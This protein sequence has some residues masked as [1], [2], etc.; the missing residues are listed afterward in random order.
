MLTLI[1]HGDVYAPEHLGTQSLLLV[2][3]RIGKIGRISRAAVEAVG[4]DVN[5]I[6]ATGCIVCPGFIDPHEHLLGGSGEEGFATQS[7]EIHLSEIVRAGITTVV[8][9][10]GVDTT[11]KTMAGLLAKAKAL[12]EEGLSAF[13]WSGGYNV[14]PVSIMKSVRE[15]MMFIDEVVG[16]GEVAISDERATDPVL[17]ELARAVTE[18]HVGGMLSRKA[19]ITHFHVG[20]GKR[21]MTC[22]EELIACDQY[23]IQPCW[24]YPT[25]IERS[26]PLMRKAIGLT[27]QGCYVD[28]DIQEE[29]LAK[30]LTFYAD[31]G[32]DLTRLT[33][34]SDASQ[35]GPDTLFNQIRNCARGHRLPL[36]KLLA[37]VTRNTSEVLKLMSKGRL[38]TGADGDILVLEKESF[39]IVHVLARGKPMVRDGDLCVEEQFLEKSNRRITLRGARRDDDGK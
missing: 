20:P 13:I 36:P 33:V 30:W 39:D 27:K 2:D 31:H 29:D 14:P 26:A 5:V 12:K 28:M 37:L 6:D 15:D 17:S 24:L 7:P 32:G 34:S 9:T 3:G 1:E 18:T 25:H 4:I 11:M 10:L 22:L 21:M 23:D 16:A 8:G 35:K 38:E 19:G